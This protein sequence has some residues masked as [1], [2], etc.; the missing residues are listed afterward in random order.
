[1]SRHH[2]SHSVQPII[3]QGMG[4][5]FC[6]PQKPRNKKKNSTIVSVP[7]H[8]F[9]HQKL[10][11]ELNDLLTHPSSEPSKSTSV[12]AVS[13]IPIP[14]GLLEEDLEDMSFNFDSKEVPCG[15]PT[16]EPVHTL[17]PTAMAISLCTSWKVVIPTIIDP[18]LKY[19]AAMLGKPLDILDSLLL[20]CLMSV[21]VHICCCSTLPQTLVSH[22]LFPTVL[23]QPR[24]A[25][26]V[27]LLSF[28]QAL[29]EC[30]CNAI[31]ALSTALSTYYYRQGFC[32]TNHKVKLE[33]QV[34]NDIECCQLLVKAAIQPFNKSI[35]VQHCPACFGGTLFRRPLDKCGD[36]HVATDGNFHHWHQHSA[37]DFPLFYKPSYFLSK[38]QVDTVGW[39]I[40]Q[41]HQHPSAMSQLAVPNKV[42]DECEASYE[43]A[44]SKKQK[45]ALDSFDN[46]GEQQK[47]SV[48]LLSHL[49]SLLLAHANMVILYNVGC[50]LAHSLTCHSQ[51][52]ILN[53]AIMSH[54]CFATTAM[55]A[56]GHQWACQFVYNPCLISGLG[57]SDGEAI[58]YEMQ[59]ELRDWLRCHLR[60][61]VSEQ[62]SATQ[63]TLN[64]CGMSVME[65]QEQWK[66]QHTTQLSIRAYASAKLKKELDTALAL[67]ANL[68]SINK[69]LQ[70]TQRIIERGSTAPGILDALVSFEHTHM[71]LM[72]KAEAFYTSLNTLMMAHDLKI[73]ICKRVVGGR[74]NPL[75]TRLHQQTCKAIAR[76]Q[77]SLMAAI[78]KYNSYC[79]HLSELYDSSWVI[80]LPASLPTK[81]DIW[82]TPSEG[83]IPQWPQDIDEHCLEEQCHLS[84]EADNMCHWFGSELSAIQLC[85]EAILEL[86]M[87]WPTALSSSSFYANQA[88]VAIQLVNVIAGA[89]LPFLYWLTPVVVDDHVDDT[90]HKHIIGHSDL[91]D[92]DL[93]EPLLTPE[94][95]VLSDLFAEGHPVN[96][97]ELE[98]EASSRVGVDWQVPHV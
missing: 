89:S 70:A 76:C 24:M 26:S 45:T 91:L 1:M 66:N 38:A 68:D 50:I 54:I 16:V 4:W 37:S 28:Y 17:N 94:Q 34:N 83:E 90:D 52:K 10:L 80:P 55:H 96:Q 46:M 20:L 93:V 47:Y 79:Q 43:A 61:G 53:Q 74:D 58:S 81:L 9:K 65:L 13:P 56:Y 32:V 86:Q 72:T 36:I 39:C 75:G 42:I 31:N 73:N 12:K 30:S 62:G 98:F 84:L 49:F 51:F 64:N 69:M 63:E 92:T 40:D 22:G 33:K 15:T 29:F 23:S 35:L 44:D 48:A 7:G 59:N 3:T 95:A 19:T 67:Q 78:C 8:A 5:H 60:K 21:D 57:L 82:I 41:A 27:E 25:V 2:G 85:L 6:S 97:E 14:Q 87:Q 77:P 88:Q 71:R 18:F 11:D